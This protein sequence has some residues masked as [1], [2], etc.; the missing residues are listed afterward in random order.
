VD[1]IV[2]ELERNNYSAHTL[3]N[4]V[5]MSMPFRYQI[6]MPAMPPLSRSKASVQPVRKQ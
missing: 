5:V 4:S 1:S 6:G 3:I 2:T